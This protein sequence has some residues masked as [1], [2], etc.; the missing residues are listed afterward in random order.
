MLRIDHLPVPLEYGDGTLRAAAADKLR[1]DRTRIERVD[2]IRRSVDAT[3]Q[4]NV[5]FRVSLRVAVS[6]DEN[7][8]LYRRADKSITRWIPQEYQ[9]PVD[10]RPEGRFSPEGVR[11]DP[12]GADARPVVV[13]CGPAGLFAALTLARAGAAPIVLERGPGIERRMECVRRFLET[14]IL[15]PEANIQFG[16]GGAGAFSDGKLKTGRVDALK[17]MI[18]RELVEAGA[19]PEILYIDKPH[20]GTDRLPGTVKNL[21]EKIH[22]LGGEVRFETKVTD[23]LSEGGRV[24]GVSVIRDGRRE[25]IP[26]GQVIL[27][28]GNSARDLFERFAGD[29]GIALASRPFAVGVRIE[30]PASLIDRLRY[31]R[32]AGH[33]SLG[34]ADYRMTVHLAGGRGVYTFCMCP[35]GTVVAA[36]SEYDSVVTNGMSPYARNGPNSNSAILVTTGPGDWG[37]EGPLAGMEY[38]RAIERRG[39]TAGG[40]GYRAPVQRLEDFLSRRESAGFGEVLPTYRPGTA[41]APV[42]AY[43]PP[44]IADSLRQ[45]ILEM[46][47]WMPGFAFPDA[48]LTGPETR[49]SSPVRIPR[50]QDLQADGMKGLYPCGEGAGY[51]GGIVSAAADGVRC[52]ERILAGGEG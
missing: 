10:R 32:A 35:G 9:P 19:P 36:S 50:G 34:A 21:R 7:E 4:E 11:P 18:L 43:L 37:S 41:F 42:D 3:D 45:A 12:A 39:Y 8:V 14:G 20:I 22:R 46:D 27:A 48:L 49:S 28:A 15:D 44:A 38:Q 5:H 1:V 6:G 31:G 33:P 30:H 25:Q 2:L 29:A 47:D 23:I 13:G 51:S 52:A 40:G 26:A 17:E 24:T 16:E